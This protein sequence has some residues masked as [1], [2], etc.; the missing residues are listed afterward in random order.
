M[1]VI[2]TVTAQKAPEP[3]TNGDRVVFAGN[4]IT[5]AGFYGMYIWQ[6]YQLHFPNERITMLNG[7]I[8]G[9]VAGQIANRFELDIAL[10]KPTVVVLTFG[11][12]DS[13][14]FEYFNEP[15]E[16]VRKEAVATSLH[17]YKQLETKLNELP[18]ARKILMTSSPFD[19]TRA[20]A[21][22]KFT[23]KYKTMLEI[24]A[25]QQKAAKKNKWGFVD[26]LRP[27]TTINK[28]GQTR[29]SMFTLTG[30]DR[31]HPGNAGHMVMAWLF[32]KAQGMAGQ[33]VADVCL[34]AKNGKLIR[35]VNS[36]I[37]NVKTMNGQLS[38]DYLAKSL[39]FPSDSIARVFE[40]SQK[41]YEA[42]D[43][44][45]FTKEMN[46]E[47]L[48][49]TGLA[50]DKRYELSIDGNAVGTWTGYAFTKGINIA[51]IS[52]TP[53]YK[54][55]Q[56]IAALNLQYREYEQKLRAYYWLQVNY[57]KKHNMLFRDDQTAMDSVAVSQE[58]GVGS[59]KDNYAEAR[60]KEKRAQW[61]QSMQEIVDRI[62]TINK[63]AVHHFLIT[64]NK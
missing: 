45:P 18:E 36:T 56:E 59:K 27:M 11:M 52:S 8:G 13:R 57:F 41:Q 46:Q 4:S 22:N 23:G 15:E 9:D 35:A 33:V 60:K 5:E 48:T 1:L 38:F 26:L 16:K 29:D 28:R 64:E 55:A 20:G 51:I 61:Q 7:G 21:N 2:S 3:F 14:Y 25:F 42:L 50:K 58:W 17:S 31:I 44:I 54:Q 37:T 24:A 63:P 53:Q 30:P 19:E 47:L 10:L 40:N 49:V 39:P 34:N 32:L 62:Y 6:Y 43:V 12:N